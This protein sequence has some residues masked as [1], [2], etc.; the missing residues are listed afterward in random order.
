MEINQEERM[1]RFYLFQ[2][3]TR[4]GED[5]HTIKKTLE[6]PDGKTPEEVINDWLSDFYGS[7]TEEYDGAFWSPDGC[8]AVMSKGWHNISKEDFDVLRR[9]GI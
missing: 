4:S 1:T 6:V 3:E 5:E 8:Y 9:H 7:D 2:Y